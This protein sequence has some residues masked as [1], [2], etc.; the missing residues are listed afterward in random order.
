M[1]QRSCGGGDGLLRRLAARVVW[2]ERARAGRGQPAV[3]GGGREL[4]RGAGEVRER[5]DQPRRRSS[6]PPPPPPKVDDGSAAR[7]PQSTRSQRPRRRERAQDRGPAAQTLR[8]G[9]RRAGERDRASPAAAAAAANAHLMRARTRRA[10]AHLGPPARPN[11]RPPSSREL[12]AHASANPYPLPPRPLPSRRTALRQGPHSSHGPVT[13]RQIVYGRA[14]GG[15][16]CSAPRC[17][18]VSLV[19]VAPRARPGEHPSG[20]VSRKLWRRAHSRGARR[21]AC[22][23]LA[24]S[25]DELLALGLGSCAQ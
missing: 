12:Q 15:V 25:A 9:K 11:R 24:I 7:A 8:R 22:T 23:A 10:R 21:W 3:R 4:R 13:L 20:A 5:R 14:G 17:A 2:A 16:S 18:S 1:S 19:V 6:A